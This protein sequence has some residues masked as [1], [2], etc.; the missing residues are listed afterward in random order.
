MKNSAR[1][2][3][4]YKPRDQKPSRTLR[5]SE[6]KSGQSC[7][8]V[9][10][11]TSQT[12]LL[13]TIRSSNNLKINQTTY[14]WI[15]HDEMNLPVPFSCLVD[16]GDRR[17]SS[18]NVEA[19]LSLTWMASSRNHGL[20]RP[21]FIFKLTPCSSSLSHLSIRTKKTGKGWESS[22]IFELEDWNTT[23]STK[24]LKRNAS[25]EPSTVIFWTWHELD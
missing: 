23:C 4:W 17:N 7:Q 11:L 18:A 25:S 13:Q 16:A 8:K 12:F 24:C 14:P 1:R 9:N 21:P 6:S 22:E 19:V 5:I 20:H 2:T 3:Q 10:A 15:Q